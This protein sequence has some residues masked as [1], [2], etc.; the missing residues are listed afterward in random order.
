M[1]ASSSSTLRLSAL[2]DWCS[3]SAAARELLLRATSR[4]TCAASQSGSSRGSMTVRCPPCTGAAL[5]A[6]GGMIA[7]FLTQLPQHPPTGDGGHKPFSLFFCHG[8]GPVAR[9]AL[10]DEP[11]VIRLLLA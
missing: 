11:G 6:R 3:F 2:T 8:V 4:N 9:P 7:A 5:A 10:Q 1:R